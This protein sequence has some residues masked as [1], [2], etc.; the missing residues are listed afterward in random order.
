VQ[1]DEQQRALD[2]N[3]LRYL[4]SMRS[5]YIINDRVS[6]PG[7][8][9]GNLPNGISINVAPSDRSGRRERLRFRDMIWAFYSE[10]Q[11]LLLNASVAA[12]GG[13]LTWPD[14]RAL[15]IPLWLTSIESL[16]SKLNISA[17]FSHNMNSVRNL[18]Q[19]HAMNTWRVIFVIRPG[20]PSS[21]LPLENTN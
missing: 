13:K 1:I 7:K 17:T 5:F 14:A 21:I 9:A 3:G 6:N 12:C 8:P 11:E 20:V 4:I 19:L 2:A 15:G 16:V 18:R 10:S